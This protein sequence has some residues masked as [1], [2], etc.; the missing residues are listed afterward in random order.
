[1]V[2]RRNPLISVAPWWV[3]LAPFFLW[4]PVAQ[5]A[6]VPATVRPESAEM[7]AQ[8]QQMKFRRRRLIYNNDGCDIY[9]DAASTPEGF[10]SQRME[11][12]PGSQVD[13]VFYCTGATVMFSHEAKVGEIYGEYPTNARKLIESGTDTLKLV[14]DF[15]RQHDLEVFFTHRINDVHD[16][17]DCNSYELAKWKLEHP[18]YLLGRREDQHQHDANDPRYWW[19]ALNFEVDAVRDYL[20]S[21][22][23]DVCR[24]YDIDGI[25][26]D[27][28]RSPMF[29]KHNGADGIY[30][31]NTVPKKPGH[32][33]FTQLGDAEALRTA[34][35]VFVIDNKLF[36]EGDLVQAIV[37]DQILPVEAATG[38]SVEVVLPVSDDVAQAA[39]QGRL[40]RLLLHVNCE[41]M[42]DDDRLRTQLNGREV[43]PHSDAISA[44][45]QA[46]LSSGA[47]RPKAQ[48]SAIVAKDIP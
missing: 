27:Y 14:I 13:S 18:E 26:I 15:C 39:K 24:R 11:A 21:I 3:L 41:P 44:D 40:E 33:H 5:P 9:P 22:I 7:A 1:M 17:V 34:D 8:R 37:Q 6:E 47:P 36:L 10:L 12:V 42:S 43:T 20:V 31:F 35:K 19:S 45:S 4:L 48:S 16:A 25:E 28:F 30:L 32:P 23:E 2:W 29:F 46:E 38:K